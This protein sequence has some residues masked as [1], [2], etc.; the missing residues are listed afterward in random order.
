MNFQLCY[1]FQ[2]VSV[3]GRRRSRATHIYQPYGLDARTHKN[4]TRK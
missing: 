1:I 3:R 2:A 4:R